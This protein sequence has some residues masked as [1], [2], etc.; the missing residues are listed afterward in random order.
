MWGREKIIHEIQAIAKRD[1]KVPG[2]LRFESVTGLNQHDWCGK[3]W[4]R[5]NDAIAEAG[6]APNE[7]Q[8]AIPE[9]ILLGAFLDLAIKLDRIPADADLRLHGRS[10]PNS[11]S[12]STYQKRFGSKQALL[13]KVLGFAVEHDAPQHL[14]ETIRSSIDASDAESN[15]SE[16]VAIRGFVYLL[17][18]GRRYKIGKTTSPLK[19]LGQIGIELPER[20]EPIHT[21]ETD[22]P[23]GIEAYWHNRFRD[24][25]LN[26]E[27]FDLSAAD[28]RAFRRR[29][30]FM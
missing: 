6:L 23:A 4:A 3:Y 27:W 28:V 1:G 14:I 29:R 8:E 15:V 10:N 9:D 21:I 13:G 7:K 17:K 11:P 30:K 18:S 20:S 19:R 24:K 16:D 22:D 26:G 5:W 2:R 12:L 25:R